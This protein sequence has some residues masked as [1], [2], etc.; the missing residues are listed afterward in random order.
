[1]VRVCN[2]RFL[3]LSSLLWSLLPVSTLTG[4]IRE[5]GM[6]SMLLVCALPVYLY[7]GQIWEFRVGD[8]D[9]TRVSRCVSYVKDA[10]Y[11]KD[12]PMLLLPAAQERYRPPTVGGFNV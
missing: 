4:E 6:G 11:S 10:R 9:Q 1:M 8:D 7:A 5:D 12:I 2:D 3:S